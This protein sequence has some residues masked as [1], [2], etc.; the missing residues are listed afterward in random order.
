MRTGEGRAPTRPLHLMRTK[1]PGSNRHNYFGDGMRKKVT[2]LFHAIAA[3]LCLGGILGAGSAG[4]QGQPSWSDIDRIP[5]PADR[6]AIAAGPEGGRVIAVCDGPCGAQPQVTAIQRQSGK[7][8]QRYAIPE[9]DL[10]AWAQNGKRV[11][12]AGPRTAGENALLQID[13]G[14][15]GAGWTALPPIAARAES[16]AIDGADLVLATRTPAGLQVTRQHADGTIEALGPAPDADKPVLA[17]APYLETPTIHLFDAATARAWRFDAA[18]RSWSSLDTGGRRVLQAVPFAPWWIATRTEQ[19]VSFFNSVTATW[20]DS[21]PMPGRAIALI[22][23]GAQAPDVVLATERGAEVI[24]ERFASEGRSVSW[25]DFAIIVAYPLGLIAIGLYF[26]H[27]SRTG[28]EYFRGGQRL[29]GWAA[30]VAL[31]GAKMSPISFISVPGATF[32]GNWTRLPFHMAQLFIVPIATR[33]IIPIMYRLN[34]TSVYQ[35][36]E[37]RFGLT[38]RVA[39]AVLYLLQMIAMIGLYIFLPGLVVSATMGVDIYATILVIGVIATFYAVIG[40]LE[41]IAWVEVGEVATLFFGALLGLFVAALAIPG[42]PLNVV[43]DWLREGK[44]TLFLPSLSLTQMSALVFLLY[45][46]AQAAQYMS[47]QGIVLR[48]MSTPSLR[49]AKRSAWTSLLIGL[50]VIFAF[51]LLGSVFYSRYASAP[52]TL[53]MAVSQSDE[54]FPIFIA[55]ELPTGLVGAV[56]GVIFG[57]AMSTFS[58][59]IHTV[60]SVVTTDLYARFH[61][62]ASADR[63]GAVGRI[64]TTALGIIGTINAVIVATLP[65]QALI[66]RMYE[67]ISFVIGLVSGIF[68]LGMLVP[69]AHGRGVL[70]GIVFALAVQWYLKVAT[71]LH[72]FVFSFTGLALTVGMGWIFSELIRP[73]DRRSLEGLTFFTLTPKP[74][75]AEA[76][77]DDPG[78][79]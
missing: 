1:S 64:V 67:I 43:G 42:T 28:D 75:T 33:W 46:P 31:I 38:I 24:R 41:A 8:W 29:P 60:S 79:H 40:G 10:N 68:V 63:I 15:G 27:R 58:S 21:T 20:R 55:F 44:T 65:A 47:N 51:Y 3:L 48:Y 30:G 17:V 23:G 62:N 11:V 50:P 72:F 66:D 16:L 69:R 37:L 52:D 77:L 45:L 14:V 22:G 57:S 7:S 34:I 53:P 26:K 19:G 73:A 76:D 70:L 49:E 56:I 18:K 74:R 59:A 25:I 2:R 5:E 61:P 54:L 36:L 32:A 9:F 78:R 4:A 35:Y 13:F 6:I 12:L 71:D 39:S